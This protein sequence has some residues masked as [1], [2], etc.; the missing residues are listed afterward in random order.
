MRDE[1]Y[2]NTSER[3]DMSKKDF[4][5]L[6]QKMETVR[7]LKEYW[8]SKGE[9]MVEKRYKQQADFT[10]RYLQ[11]NFDHKIEVS[12]ALLKEMTSVSMKI[13]VFI[14]FNQ[15]NMFLKQ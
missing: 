9:D 4:I 13:G 7:E 3:E 6:S 11:S 15:E 12:S 10:K 5:K 1:N 14:L 8:E 2:F